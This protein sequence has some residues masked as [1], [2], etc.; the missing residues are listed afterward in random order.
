MKKL[1][2]LLLISISI[3]VTAQEKNTCVISGG[4]GNPI[5]SIY[6]HY[7]TNVAIGGEGAMVIANNYFI[8]GFGLETSGLSNARTDVQ[9]YKH[10]HIENEYGGLWIGYI[11]RIKPWLYINASGKIGSGELR[12]NNRSK[13]TTTYDNIWVIKPQLDVDFKFLSILGITA[14]IGYQQFGNVNLQGTGAGQYNG[15]ETHF[16]IR[17]G[18]W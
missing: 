15:I 8:G 9:E 1:L 18:W 3:H 10:D 14:G 11:W 7:G 13:H 16:G 5:V 6:N 12:F 17:M 2:T 4:F